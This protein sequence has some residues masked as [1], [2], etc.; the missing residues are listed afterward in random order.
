MIVLRG[1]RLILREITREDIPI[2]LEW[3]N[4]SQFR[5]YCSTRRNEVTLEDFTSELSADFA[6]DR[7]LQFLI[8]RRG[9]PIGTIYA[10]GVNQTD[11]YAY[12]TVF[13]FKDY[14]RFFGYGVESF[15]IFTLFLFRKLDLY[16]VYTEA[17]SY[18]EHSITCLTRAGFT[19]EG[20]FVGHRM[21]QSVRYDL[22][23]FSFFARELWKLEAF[24]NRLLRKQSVSFV[25]SGKRGDR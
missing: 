6:K 23:R 10:Y 22:V 17:Y 20:R 5:D 2:L 14:E 7:Y 13:L 9:V 3:R 12:I 19:E 16:K 11:K 8:I 24:V 25:Q 21:H 18:N 1:R 15:A 4:S